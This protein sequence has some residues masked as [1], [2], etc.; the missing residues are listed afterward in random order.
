MVVFIVHN[1]VLIGIIV[2]SPFRR[3]GGEDTETHG[4]ASLEFSPTRRR[5]GDVCH[6]PYFDD[7]IFGE[8]CSF[9][10]HPIFV[11]ICFVSDIYKDSEMVIEQYSKRD[12]VEKSF[13]NLTERIGL[14]RFLTGK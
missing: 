3:L 13:E 1:S 12:N 10:Y 11:I 2:M 14:K 6:S 8:I 7:D 9:L 4:R 5:N